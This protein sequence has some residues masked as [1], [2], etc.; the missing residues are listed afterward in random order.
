M[1]PDTGVVNKL[2]WLTSTPH[3]GDM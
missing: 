2:I 1:N 3:Q